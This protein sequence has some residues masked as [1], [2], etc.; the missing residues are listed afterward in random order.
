MNES[1]N[2][3]LI[4]IIKNGN[5]SLGAKITIAPM[6]KLYQNDNARAYMEIISFDKLI[7][8][9]EKRNRVLFDKLG[10]MKIL[11][12]QLKNTGCCRAI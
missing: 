9:A 1:Y 5:N 6:Q 10:R 4:G 7:N 11:L 12:R 3:R 8:D 2:F